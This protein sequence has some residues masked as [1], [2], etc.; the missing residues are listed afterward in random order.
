MAQRDVSLRSAVS[1]S[2]VRIETPEGLGAANGAAIDRKSPSTPHYGIDPV[3][4]N[5][6]PQRQWTGRHDHTPRYQHTHSRELV[7]THSYS[8]ANNSLPLVQGS[9][10]GAGA[11]LSASS[12]TRPRPG[13]LVQHTFPPYSVT[14]LEVIAR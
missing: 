5:E 13:P 1:R 9:R 2:R 6:S 4:P 10:L 3:H 8:T 14:V 12:P 7:H 11:G